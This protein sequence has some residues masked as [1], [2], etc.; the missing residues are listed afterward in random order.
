MSRG[1]NPICATA[2]RR[3]VAGRRRP[4]GR[5]LHRLLLSFGRRGAFRPPQ[6]SLA[7][8]QEQTADTR[9][10][11][12]LTPRYAGHPGQSGILALQDAEGAFV[13]RLLLAATAERTLDG[14]VLYLERRHHRYPADA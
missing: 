10:G 4:G 5:A 9:L 13:A 3:T 7:P 11:Q 8:A 12:L 14:A 6:P 2:L 1:E